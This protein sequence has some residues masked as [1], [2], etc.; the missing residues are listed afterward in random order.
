MFDW[1]KG[2]DK[3]AE[4]FRAPDT[5][6][7]VPDAQREVP[8]FTPH[9]LEGELPIP[10]RNEA[11]EG[12]RTVRFEQ[13]KYGKLVEYPNGPIPRGGGYTLTGKSPGFPEEFT[14]PRCMPEFTGR[15]GDGVDY[16]DPANTYAT[17]ISKKNLLGKD[18]KT[19]IVCTR[20][21]YPSEGGHEKMDRRFNEY[22]TIAIPAEEWTV[23]AV[24]LL[25]RL[26]K[27]EP[28]TERNLNLPPIE[29]K[30]GGLDK[31]PIRVNTIL[32]MGD[33]IIPN[34]FTGRGISLDHDS[35]N[36]GQTPD[37][38]MF[39]ILAT[40]PQSVAREVSFN[41]GMDHAGRATKGPARI[42]QGS[43]IYSDVDLRK[44][45]W[46]SGK[47]DEQCDLSLGQEYMTEL[48][49]RLPPA[50]EMITYR[51]LLKAVDTMPHDLVKRARQALFGKE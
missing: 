10:E 36:T 17:K 28:A 41:L 1:L 14:E 34:L 43:C 44:G 39:V 16:Q 12:P 21:A 45:Q 29:V 5:S 38:A 47:K 15:H 20:T 33:L 37:I 18:G 11:H 49:L 26:L 35:I 19:Y 48:R 51:D 25:Y 50:E 9:R 3:N 22:H 2:K 24:P 8:T 30:T 42:N 4:E 31:N 7:R 32:K 13:A 40:L 6:S 23:A 46:T 27:P